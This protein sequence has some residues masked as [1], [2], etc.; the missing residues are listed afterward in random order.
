MIYIITPYPNVD[1]LRQAAREYDSLIV[2]LTL[3]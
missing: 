3:Y 1:K 2:H